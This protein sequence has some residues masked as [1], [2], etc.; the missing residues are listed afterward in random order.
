MSWLLI[1]ILSRWKTKI[2]QPKDLTCC[3]K[4]VSEVIAVE[5]KLTFSVHQTVLSRVCYPLRPWNPATFYWAYRSWRATLTSN[6]RLTGSD[7]CFAKSLCYKSNFRR[8]PC[9]GDGSRAQE[10][11]ML[12]SRN[13]SSSKRWRTRKRKHKCSTVHFCLDNLS[14]E[15]DT[16]SWGSLTFC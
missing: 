15:N 11:P 8:K 16:A 9:I 10:R 5:E 2:K 6:E 14:R 1:T 7:T 13:W 3:Q 4:P 12:C